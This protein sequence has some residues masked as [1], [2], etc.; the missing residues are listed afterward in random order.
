MESAANQ[1]DYKKRLVSADEAV[2]HIKSGDSILISHACGEPQALID[3]MVDNYKNYKDVRIYHE[4]CMG[5]AKY[6]EP[7][8]AGHF[9]H[10]A[11]FVGANVRKAVNEGRA[12]Y[13]PGYF[14][15]IPTL[16]RDGE[17]KLDVALLQSSLPDANGYVSFGISVDYA[18]AAVE[19]AQTVIVQ[20]NPNMPRTLGNSFVHIDDIDYLVEADTPLIELHPGAISEAE[21]AIGRYCASLVEDGSC[22]QL[23]IGSIPDA[24]LA[25]L[26][27]KKDLGLHTEMFAD[28]ALDLIES[29]VINCRAKNFHPNKIVA[30]FLMGTRKLYDFVDDN[31]FVEMQ[32]VDYVNDP[33]IASKNDKLVAINSCIEVDLKGQVASESAGLRQI[34]GVGGQVDFCRAA[35]LSKGGKAILAFPSLTRKGASKIVPFLQQGA[36]V[37]TNMY[38][39]EYFVTENG[40]AN[41]RMKNLEQ[42]ARALISIAHP[43]VQDEL[44]AEY[45]DR[46]KQDYKAMSTEVAAGIGMTGKM[47]AE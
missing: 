41:L 1:I 27:D 9:F 21:A 16:I 14:H 40:I 19:C 33:Y 22:L 46:F 24:V 30:T 26:K 20:V 23:G 32:P 2:K 43:S 39:V 11:L 15:T 6:C 34:S 28:G 31:P 37:T 13:V 38:D 3:A 47:K 10:D 18:L 25:N 45:E 4:V 44:I 12:G 7:E 8:M 29:G 35:R 36:T 5:E 42:R 17:L